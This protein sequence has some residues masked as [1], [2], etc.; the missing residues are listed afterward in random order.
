MRI[1]PKDLFSVSINDYRLCCQHLAQPEDLTFS[2]QCIDP[3]T[4]VLDAFR[5]HLVHGPA[6]PRLGWVA[7]TI[8]CVDL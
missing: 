7:V 5:H 2:I 8:Q 1:A 3:L 4:L 6:D